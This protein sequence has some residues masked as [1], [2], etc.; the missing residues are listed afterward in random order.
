MGVFTNNGLN[1]VA[2]AGVNPTWVAIGTGAGTLSSALTNGVMYTSIHLNAGT[3]AN[4]ASG[5]SMTL[6][7]GT[8]TQTVTTSGTVTAGA[9]SIPVTSFTASATFAINTTGIAPT[10]AATDLV[11]Y[12]EIARVA[13]SANV[14]G[15]SAGETLVNAYFDGTQATNLYMQVGYF[16]GAATS[17]PGSGTLMIE[18]IQYWSHTLNNDSATFQA[19]STI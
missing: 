16:G 7:D 15:A 10:P 12:N 4:L 5:Q 9:T 18:D 8:N 2:A 11:L 3:P 17:T 13:V 19:D 1:L 14:T 6:Y